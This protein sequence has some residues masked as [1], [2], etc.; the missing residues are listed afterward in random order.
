MF[1]SL[2]RQ[3]QAKAYEAKVDSVKLPT[4]DHR[5]ILKVCMKALKGLILI[6]CNVCEYFH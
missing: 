1:V 4:A 2:D 5:I 3:A 6:V